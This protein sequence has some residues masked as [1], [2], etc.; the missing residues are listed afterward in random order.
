M[1]LRTKEL[2][3]KYIF[4]LLQTSK[5][6]N[7][8]NISTGTKMPRADWTTVSNKTFI[9]PTNLNESERIGTLLSTLD[10]YINLHQRKINILNKMKK[11]FLKKTFVDK[12]KSYPELRFVNFTEK[13]EDKKLKD[14]GE[15]NSGIG[16]PEKEQRGQEGFPFYKV[17]D[18][19]THGN[20][21]EMHKANNY[22]DEKQL[23]EN[24]WKLVESVPA[25]IF[26]KVGA[27]LLLNRKRLINEP[28]LLDNNT[29]YFSF[30]DNL[31]VEFGFSLFETIFLPRY[32]QVGA[33]PSFNAS[34]IKNI[35][36]SI[37]IEEEQIKIGKHFKKLDKII[38]LNERK[39]ELLKKYK[40]VYLN[41][42]FI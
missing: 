31:D 10:A 29:M 36:V 34:D 1:V 5:F 13:W 23:K 30:K 25:V 8:S 15:I 40:Q 19:N 38:M 21:R 11:D 20:E 14:L 35:K 42:M 3:S 4:Y 9:V 41:K 2:N 33:L 17:S 32:A 7:V 26:A 6:K 12:E 27:A 18:M 28:F 22:V 37:P 24:R 39:L 16:F